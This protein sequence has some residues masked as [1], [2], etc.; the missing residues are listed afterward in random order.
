MEREK[1][2]GNFL[3]YLMLRQ[4]SFKACPTLLPYLF[5]S[6]PMHNAHLSRP[7]SMGGGI[8]FPPNLSNSLC[9]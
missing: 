5:T 4:S 9:Q 8:R 1:D 7:L 3:G 6:S 2:Y